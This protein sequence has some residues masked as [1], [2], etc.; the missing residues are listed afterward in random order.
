[1]V[2]IN[3]NFSVIDNNGNKSV[4]A[5]C[6]LLYNT[7]KETVTNLKWTFDDGT[8]AY[9]NNVSHVYTVF[10][11][12]S[13]TATFQ[14]SIN[15]VY[16]GKWMTLSKSFNVNNPNEP[17]ELAGTTVLDVFKAKPIVIPAECTGDIAIK[18]SITELDKL[19]DPPDKS[20][21]TSSVAFSINFATITIPGNSR[22]VLPFNDVTASGSMVAGCKVTDCQDIKNVANIPAFY[23]R[24]FFNIDYS[25]VDTEDDDAGLDVVWD[26]WMDFPTIMTSCPWME[27]NFATSSQ[28]FKNIIRSDRSE[29]LFPSLEVGSILNQQFTVETWNGVPPFVIREFVD[30]PATTLMVKRA[31]LAYPQ[32][33]LVAENKLAD[34]VT[35][36][37]IIV[38]ATWQF[39]PHGWFMNMRTEGDKRP[40][41][42]MLLTLPKGAEVTRNTGLD[43]PIY[44]VVDGYKRFTA[45]RKDE[46]VKVYGKW[47]EYHE[48]SGDIDSYY[49]PTF[50]EVKP[51][52]NMYGTDYPTCIYKSTTYPLKRDDF[53]RVSGDNGWM[54]RDTAIV[55]DAPSIAADDIYR[56]IKVSVKNGQSPDHKFA[57]FVIETMPNDSLNFPTITKTELETNVKKLHFFN[58]VTNFAT[59]IEVPRSSIDPIFYETLSKTYKEAVILES[60]SEEP[61]YRI[62]FSVNNYPKV[63]PIRD[64]QTLSFG[65]WLSHAAD[66]IR[67]SEIFVMDGTTP[68]IIN[69]QCPTKHKYMVKF[70]VDYKVYD[71]I[72]IATDDDFPV[73]FKPVTKTT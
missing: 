5:L 38:K 22:V 49:F 56:N 37:N 29:A 12:H 31:M 7:S 45:T 36:G 72:Y 50:V 59:Y 33:H 16:Y 54:S 30:E 17:D 25:F 23:T 10:S 28:I 62:N 11:N 44:V 26:L 4:L 53:I 64:G 69:M 42:Q 67:S 13:V 41:N 1:M 65:D 34:S 51:V 63:V 46:I 66:G 24:G 60:I 32:F 40:K 20:T 3:V 68:N 57:T 15:G 70:D 71:N 55:I 18:A 2:S 48:A 39:N 35:L 47:N 19:N 73:G 43:F 27:G 9:E 21:P 58:Y 6:T 61:L 52:T 14:H 8:I